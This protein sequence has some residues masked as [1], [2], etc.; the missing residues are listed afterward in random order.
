MYIKTTYRIHSF[1]LRTNGVALNDHDYE[2]IKRPFSTMVQHLSRCHQN[3][4]LADFRS[5]RP[6]VHPSNPDHDQHS[7]SFENLLIF[8]AS[9]ELIHITITTFHESLG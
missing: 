2:W 5:T 1:R 3:S 6:L 4:H 7:L 9:L 8:A